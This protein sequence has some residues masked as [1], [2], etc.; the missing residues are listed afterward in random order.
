ML[1]EEF[2]LRFLDLL[3]IKTKSPDL[4]YLSEIVRAHFSAIPFE[5][6]S[7][8]FYNLRESQQQIPSHDQYLKGIEMHHFGGTCY[9]NNFYL[10]EL[11][12]FLGFRAQI[13]GADMKKPD[14]HLVIMVTLDRGSYLVDTGYAAPFL[15]P[16]PLDLAED[17]WMDWGRD[18]FLIR[19][20]DNEGRTHLMMFRNNRIRHGYIVRSEPKELKDFD[21]AISDS[22][23]PEAP[24]FTSLL[25]T[26]YVSDRYCMIHN[27]EFIES[28]PG[29][30]RISSIPDLPSLYKL[31]EERF[32]I[33][34]WITRQVVT[35]KVVTG[36]AWG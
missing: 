21:R 33:P 6:I 36:D 20:R 27:L 2:S 10:Y 30:S 18:R 5:N 14:S 25:L 8:L 24:F 1:L 11:L 13:C 7:K 32:Q 19:P 35:D 29:K 17:L 23:R 16:I 26:K 22:Y 3:G 15:E 4:S 9:S 12:R 31:V 34:A 28:W